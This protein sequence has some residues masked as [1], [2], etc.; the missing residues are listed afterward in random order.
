[1]AVS[2]IPPRRRLVSAAVAY[3]FGSASAYVGASRPLS[4]AVVRRAP[5]PALVLDLP[6]TDIVDGECVGDRTVTGVSYREQFDDLFSRPLQTGKPV[7]KPSNE[8]NAAEPTA[9]RVPF[10]NVFGTLM[11]GPRGRDWSETDR[12]R[13]GWFILM[14]GLGLLAPFYFSWRMLGIQ[15]LLYCASGMGIT[16]SYHR[17]LA[18]KSFK[19]PKWLEYLAATCGMAAMQGSP[20]EWVSDHR[21]HHLHTET[22]L[23]PHSSYEGFYWS[24]GE[25]PYAAPGRAPIAAPCV[26]ILPPASPRAH[27]CAMGR[28]LAVLSC[29]TTSPFPPPPRNAS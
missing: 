13:L 26:A 24:H 2:G 19:S 4:P 28:L 25:P 23:D 7:P 29:C 6:K 10:S 14:H 15:F 22:P 18:H 17:Q 12:G 20:Y 5:L 1:M 27:A 9:V 11:R 16:Y 21:Y 3:L 8:A